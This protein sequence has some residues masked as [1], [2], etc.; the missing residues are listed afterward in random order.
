MDDAML[1][2]LCAKAGIE[3]QVIFRVPH[4]LGEYIEFV[5]PDTFSRVFVIAARSDAPVV[6]WQTGDALT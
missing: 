6:Y 5:P 3:C 2:A 4:L 1:E